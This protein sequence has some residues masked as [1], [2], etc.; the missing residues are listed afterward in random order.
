M[1]FRS[2]IE[3]PAGTNTMVVVS[4]EGFQVTVA[5]DPRDK[6]S[7][8]VVGSFDGSRAVATSLFSFVTPSAGLYGFRLL[9]FEGG[10]GAS[11]AW[12]STP[13]GTA[14]NK[15][16]INSPDGWKAHPRISS[17]LPPVVDILSP[18]LNAINISGAAVLQAGLVDGTG[19]GVNPG[20]V[21]LKVNGVRVVASIVKESGHTSVLY[22]PPGLMEP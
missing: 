22:D 12:Y 18:G 3:L 14:A 4:D 10:G 6:A 11:V 5:R 1:L 9:Y 20:S 13:D 8:I 17:L 15:V 2:W 21:E 16:L 7:A 19:A